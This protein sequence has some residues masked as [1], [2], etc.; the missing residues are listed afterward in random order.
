M[1]VNQQPLGQTPSQT[2]GPYFAYGLLPE[3]YGYAFSSI[4]VPDMADETTPGE[5][6]I[7]E[8]CIFD[9]EGNAIT[10]AMIEILQADASGHYSQQPR[11]TGRFN[12]FGRCGTGLIEE[13]FFRFRTVKP[14][15]SSADEA[16]HINV[17]VFM[18]G[19]MLHVF[20]R[21]YFDG[22]E[23]NGTDPVLSQVP[24]NRQRT[25]LA[26][27]IEPGI[28]RFDI[29]MQGEDETVFFDI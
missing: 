23:R 9:G 5:R 20:T 24:I 6:I 16:P 14:A 7:I 13:G 15:A 26:R 17:I 27:Q 19:I 1:T 12:G 21:L 18:R 2:V 8:G 25:L 3:Q 4:A 11:A 10:D 22:D 28:W 29:H